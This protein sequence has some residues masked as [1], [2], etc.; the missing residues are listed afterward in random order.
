MHLADKVL[1][2][3]LGHQK[4]GDHAILERSDGCDVPRRAAQH[5]L[6]IETNGGHRLL[7]ALNAN[8]NHRGFVEHD[9]L[10]AHVDERVGCPEV[11]G[12]VPGK[13]THGYF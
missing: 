13:T 1:Q 9:A 3:F 12:K 11:N 5:P 10:I 8:G 4:V 7:I 6:R 2:H